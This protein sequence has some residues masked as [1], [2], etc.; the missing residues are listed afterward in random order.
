MADN[1]KKYADQVIATGQ[2]AH[3]EDVRFGRRIESSIYPVFNHQNEVQ[4]LAI[5]GMDVTD[6]RE[7]ELELKAQAEK[8]ESIYRAAPIGIGI[9]ANRVILE[10]NE[11]FCEITGYPRDEI[12]GQSTRLLYPDDATFEQVGELRKKRR[13]PDQLFEVETK[14]KR[15]DGVIIDVLIRSSPMYTDEDAK[16]FVFTVQ[17]ITRQKESIRALQ[18]SEEMFS[19]VFNSAPFAIIISDHED[20][21][22]VD[23]YPAFTVI[24]GYEKDEVVGKSTG[25]MP[26]WQ[27]SEDKHLVF[28]L[29]DQGIRFWIRNTS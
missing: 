7:A 26:V 1:R 15:K 18:E 29:L 9:N 8:L 12:I 16:S 19:K 28:D 13:G 20:G 27:N 14:F 6:R 24:S 25:E 5:F 17:D 3:F 2:P 10:A 22:I 11:R 4:R 21:R 23:V